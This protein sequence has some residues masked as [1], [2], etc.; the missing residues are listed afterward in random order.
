MAMIKPLN[1]KQTILF[2][3]PYPPP[4]SGPEMGM[5]LF[6]KS[7]L[8]EKYNIKFLKTNVRKNNIN[9]GRFDI[10]MIVAFF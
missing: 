5:R 7:S 8:N 1:K 4:Y 9:K 6:L 3:G 2:I 10:Q